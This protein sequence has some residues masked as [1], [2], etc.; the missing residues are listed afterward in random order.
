MV[1]HGWCVFGTSANF[2]VSPVT[3]VF[4]NRANILHLLEQPFANLIAL[5]GMHEALD[6]SWP[7]LLERQER[8]SFTKKTTFLRMTLQQSSI[9]VYA[10]SC[11]WHQPLLHVSS[12]QLAAFRSL[13]RPGTGVVRST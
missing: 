1:G 8:T 11:G 10:L 9:S 6:S 7:P 12:W 2:S 5:Q 3:G 4:L 13:L